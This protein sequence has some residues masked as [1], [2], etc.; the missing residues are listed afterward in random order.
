[1]PKCLPLLLGRQVT[2]DAALESVDDMLL[3]LSYP[4][5]QE[6]FYSYLREQQSG[7]E[8]LVSFHLGLSTAE[9][10]RISE[11][12][13]WMGGYY[14]VCIPVY[15][16]DGCVGSPSS[17]RVLIRIPLAYKL[18]EAENPG[19]VEEKLRCVA[20]TFIWIQEQCPEVPI[21]YLWGFGFPSG[22]CVCTWPNQQDF[23][24]FRL[25]FRIYT[26]FVM[27]SL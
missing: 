10:C 14:N 13:E 20:A 12:G 23:N 22:Q 1:M 17:R 21:P 5:K 25:K 4:S 3:E 18:G 6:A 9:R 27:S 19:N 2:L 11:T 15:V 7:I 26:N 24:L 8:A 16:D